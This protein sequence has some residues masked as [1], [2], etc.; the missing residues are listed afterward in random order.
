MP[1][2]ARIDPVRVGFAAIMAMLCTATAQSI[3]EELPLPRWE[4]E[5]PRVDAS[6]PGTAFNS[7][8]RGET[9]VP[10]LPEEPGMLR[11]GPRLNDTPTSLSPQIGPTDLSLFLHGSL[12]QQAKPAQ[13]PRVPTPVMALRDLPVD[14]TKDLTESPANTYLIDPQNLLPEVA[15]GDLERLL[16]F[17]AGNARIRFYLLVL[18]ANQRLPDTIDPALIAYGALTRYPSCLAIYPLGEP[19]RARVLLSPSVH[20]AA[21]P[22]TLLEMAADCIRDAQQA[23]DA[24]EQLHR[25]AVRLSTRL[26][27]LQKSMSEKAVVHVGVSPTLREITSADKAPRPALILPLWSK[28]LLGCSAA[29]FILW[30]SLRHLVMRRTPPATAGQVWM[31]PEAEAQPRLGG[32]FSAGAGAVLSYKR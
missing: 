8:L 7:L 14:I 9:L 2:H 30:L 31:L 11:F 10:A 4:R 27:W 16:D 20:D 29:L 17:H 21:S 23:D 5:A 12:L 19:W 25:Y 26:F 28:L 32:A 18:D 15:R 6:D 13:A 24:D 3:D 1:L 22:E